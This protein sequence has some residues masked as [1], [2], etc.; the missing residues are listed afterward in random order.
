MTIIYKYGKTVLWL[1]EENIFIQ[2]SNSRRY[3]GVICNIT[4]WLRCII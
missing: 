1:M 3:Q 4:N 2:I